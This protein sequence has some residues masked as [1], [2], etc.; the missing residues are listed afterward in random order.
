MTPDSATL[1]SDGGVNGENAKDGFALVLRALHSVSRLAGAP[2]RKSTLADLGLD[3]LD[4]MVLRKML[5]GE[6][7]GLSLS[8]FAML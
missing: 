7:L 5:E 1:L 4:F 8:I 3:S 6:V 2:T